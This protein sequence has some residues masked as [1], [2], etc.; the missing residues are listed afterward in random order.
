MRK[1]SDEVGRADES[2]FTTV[3]VHEEGPKTADHDREAVVLIRS[4]D[5]MLTTVFSSVFRPLLLLPL[6][7]GYPKTGIEQ[8]V[9]D[10]L[11]LYTKYSSAAY[12]KLC[13]QPLGNTLIAQVRTQ[14]PETPV[15][16]SDMAH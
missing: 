2:I 12:Q 16:I 1:M 9:Y 3:V 14:L 11:V 15:I 8:Q 4:G 6:A 10:D 7:F 5:L 13:P